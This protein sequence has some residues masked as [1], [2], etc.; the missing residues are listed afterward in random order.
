MIFSSSGV[1]Q[2]QLLPQE[3]LA[4]EATWMLNGKEHFTQVKPNKLNHFLRRKIS[5]QDDFPET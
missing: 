3:L 5:Y 4:N 2:K 1:K